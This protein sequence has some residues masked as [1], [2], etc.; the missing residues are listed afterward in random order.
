MSRSRS[1]GVDQRVAALLPFGLQPGQQAGDLA[2]RGA[3][4]R[5]HVALEFGIVGMDL[6]VG[7]QHRKLPGDVL[8]VMD[9]EGKALAVFAQLLRLRQDLRG[10]L[11]GDPAGDLAPDDA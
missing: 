3:H 6:G 7:E 5:Q 9:D 10:T 1:T 11:L 4:R 2:H 8:D